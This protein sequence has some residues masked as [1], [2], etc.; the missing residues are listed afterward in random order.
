MIS[1]LMK[2]FLKRILRTFLM[3]LDL[4]LEIGELVV[5]YLLTM[6]LS[7]TECPLYA[8]IGTVGKLDPCLTPDT[9]F[10]DSFRRLKRKP[11]SVNSYNMFH[12]D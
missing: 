4:I 2:W 6:T 5:L 12:A 8:D 3:S 1:Y 9:A 11:K 7:L 10:K